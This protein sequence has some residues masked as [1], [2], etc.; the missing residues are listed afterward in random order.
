MGVRPNHPIF[1]WRKNVAS[2]QTYGDDWGFPMTF[3]KPRH[4]CWFTSIILLYIYIY[5]YITSIYSGFSYILPKL[6]RNLHL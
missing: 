4:Y 1:V 3:Q 6:K 5:I 2:I